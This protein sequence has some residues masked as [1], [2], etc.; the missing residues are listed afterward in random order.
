MSRLLMVAAFASCVAIPAAEAQSR[1]KVTDPTGTPLNVRSAPQGP[2]VGKLT[3]GN[4]VSILEN[5]DDAKGN[6]WVRIA[7]MSNN[8][9]LGWVLRE[10]VSCF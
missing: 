6:P 2:I 8:A 10:F 3:N 7:M 9:P 5:A 1:C 4:L